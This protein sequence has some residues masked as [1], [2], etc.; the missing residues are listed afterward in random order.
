MSKS[1]RVR[2]EPERW[3]QLAVGAAIL[4]VAGV[5]EAEITAE[6]KAVGEI[7]QSTVSR[8]LKHAREELKVLSVSREIFHPEIKGVEY[9]QM[10]VDLIGSDRLRSA[11]REYLGNPLQERLRAASK[12]R[13][14]RS[15][16]IVPPSDHD[17]LF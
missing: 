1:R 17:S 10:V 9:I 3:Q 6:F 16:I 5:S 7:S 2:L 15:L 8:M 13:R 12:G 11:A 14:F 4:R